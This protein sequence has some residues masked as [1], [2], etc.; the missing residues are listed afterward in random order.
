MAV[1]YSGGPWLGPQG[2]RRALAS[3]PNHHR[4][5]AEIKTHFS[6]KSLMASVVHTASP[7]V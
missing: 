6:W 7:V 2:P 4:A 5:G 1:K 3:G